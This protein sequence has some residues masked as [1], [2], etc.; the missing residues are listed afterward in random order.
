MDEW[1]PY[2]VNHKISCLLNRIL[3]RS[4][5][6]YIYRKHLK[7][8]DIYRVQNY[9][10][11]S[12]RFMRDADMRDRLSASPFLNQ[13]SRV[14]DVGA[15]TGIWAKAVYQKYRSFMYLFEPNPDSVKKLEMEFK[16]EKVRILTFGLGPENKKMMLSL[17]GMG[18]STF[19]SCPHYSEARKVEIKLRD[20]LEV[21]NELEIQEI[22]LIK[23][24]IEG[25]EYGLLRRMI[26]TGLVK[27]CKIIRVQFHDW[28]PD[29]Y[30]LRQEIVN[31]LKETH[32]VE[33]KY[34]FVWES[35]TRNDLQPSALSG[36][37]K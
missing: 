12:I 2:K 3:Y 10:A 35:W 8:E 13:S 22:D 7:Y 31:K 33:W 26:E 32:Q 25:G 9:R 30:K 29:A 5:Y 17:F 27:R 1:L 24:N 37:R 16:D 21:F 14:F 34:K 6:R 15:E 20:V 23:I 36:Q 11:S 4:F 18:S 19:N 28:Y